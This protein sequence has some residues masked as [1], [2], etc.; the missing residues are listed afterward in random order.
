MALQFA[1]AGD[2]SGIHTGAPYCLVCGYSG[3]AKEWLA[4][5]PRW[6]AALH[7]AGVEWFHSKQFFG[8]DKRGRRLG[9]YAKWLASDAERFLEKL[10][11]TINERRLTPIGVAID[12]EAF[13][14]LT[15]G[16][17]RF[18][19][20]GLWAA[21]PDLS[22]G[23]WTHN[24]GAPTKPYYLA[25]QSF[26]VQA[27]RHTPK[28]AQINILLDR[29]NVLQAQAI[30][31]FNLTVERGLAVDGQKKDLRWIAFGSSR[32]EPALQAA[33]LRTHTWYANLVHGESLD[34]E[35]DYAMHLL[36][37]KD[38]FIGICNA[39][40]MEGILGAL[41]DDVRNKLRGLK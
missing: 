39:E 29:Q 40:Y 7:D 21:P 12:V 6:Q 8:R 20:G 13:N 3:S 4:F 34:S 30:N 10:A 24:T 2:E 26:F 1:A 35:R 31:M 22:R 23:R 18:L 32:E 17:R 38:K 37:K 11:L 15:L 16:E 5:E 14:A 9:P 27:A 25:L 33:D 36:T 41:P 28:D 19:T